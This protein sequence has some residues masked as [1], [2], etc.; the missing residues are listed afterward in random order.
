VRG[1]GIG[2]SLVDS[3]LK[4]HHIALNVVSEQGKGTV[5]QLE[6]AKG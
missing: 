3:I 2:L 4:L 1:S 6:F 5:M